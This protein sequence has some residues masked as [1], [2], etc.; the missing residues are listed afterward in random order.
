MTM[1]KACVPPLV[2]RVRPAIR[3]ILASVLTL[4]AVVFLASVVRADPSFQVLGSLK[5][6]FII[7]APAGASVAL[8][9]ARGDVVKTGVVDGLGG[10]VFRNIP[11]GD[12]YVASLTY[13]GTTT[14]SG[15]TAVFDENYVP[16]QSFYDA[17]R[18]PTGLVG[19]AGYGY[20][21]TRD[22]TKLSAQVQLPVGSGPFPVLVEYSGYSP[23][24]PTPDNLA[25]GD[26]QP[27]RLISLL[28]DY[29]YVGVN[30]RGTGCS[31]GDF[32]YFEW[33]Q[34]V[35]GY[36][37]IET[38][39]AQP[40]V[41]NGQIGMVGI[42]YPGISQLF[43]AQTR[44]P[45]LAAISPLSVIDDTFRS[46][47]YP[48]GI[49]N[50]GFARNWALE[51]Q[52]QNRWPDPVGAAW[53][54]KR[55]RA[56]DVQCEANQLLRQ[57]NPDLLKKIERNPYFPVPGNPDYPDGGE[58]LT[59]Y[60]F[61]NRIVVPTFIAGAWQ[62][63]QTG[64]HWPVLLEQFAP[65]TPMRIVATNGTHTEPLGPSI[66]SSLMEFLDFH[67]ARRVPAIP[68]IAR[69]VASLLYSKVFDSPD[70][71]LPPNRFRGYN[72]N[73]A[74]SVYGAEKPVT[75]LWETGAKPGTR[76]WGSP[77][78]AAKSTYTRWPPAETVVDYW[79]FQPDSQLKRE[80]P[81]VRDDEPRAIDAFQY[82]P[83]AKPRSNFHCP[84]SEMDP[85]QC[86]EALWKAGAVYD[87]RTIPDGKALSFLSEPLP[88]QTT[89]LGSGS[90]DL[91]LKSTA[92]DID[93]EV[94]LT[95]V[96]P[97]GN[98]RYVQSGWLR[99]SHRRLDEARSTELRPRHTHLERDAAPLEGQF[100][101]VR[102]ELLPFAHVFRPGSRIR[103]SV[104]APGGNRPLWTFDVLKSTDPITNW[105]A[106]SPGRPSRVVLPLIPNV[107]VPDEWPPCPTSLRSQP[108][109][110]YVAPGAPTGVIAESAGA[111]VWVAWTAAA[112]PPGKIVTGYTITATPGGSSRAVGF[113]STRTIFEELSPGTYS[114][115][116]IAN[117]TDG[118][119]P[120][121]TP[122]NL[123]VVT[124]REAQLSR[125]SQDWRP[126]YIYTY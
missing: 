5:Q 4:V 50:D 18:L 14:H 63:E 32:D 96:R 27:F 65:E 87:W 92:A 91:W 76:T 105:I 48:G 109:R 61:V 38:I 123:A 114:F 71:K 89:M 41:K 94:T 10:L 95:E 42:S 80:V 6:I 2:F 119:S 58:I 69:V 86:P 110:L 52:N 56:G 115:M 70:I 44:P 30:I 60:A 17:Q 3:I 19:H 7:G 120:P 100:A 21:T 15:R 79:Y 46:T 28:L 108:C 51:R 103:I 24:D 54:I 40:W 13:N 83:A 64:G 11:P 81:Q 78:P 34:S 117:Y 25:A 104:E 68:E 121:S 101:L 33:L 72:Y 55:I 113:E 106:H 36:D 1:S 47:L 26:V 126:G 66:L 99:A 102:I 93:L 35:D 16:A 73:Q 97:D 22:G 49:F 125:P 98:E 62:D 45:H 118:Q 31:G 43:V 29:A 107:E 77:E 23:S 9:D 74:R 8:R 37:V 59:P 111:A 124:D 84:G 53:V 88:T 82:D 57:Q 112:A 75:I 116:I 12:G 90:V 67:V 39:A 20:I 85:T 122:S